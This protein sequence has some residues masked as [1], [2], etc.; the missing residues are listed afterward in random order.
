MV[1]FDCPDGFF[2][3]FAGLSSLALAPFSRCPQPTQLVTLGIDA[4]RHDVVLSPSSCPGLT[5]S[6]IEGDSRS[7]KC[8][9]GAIN[10]AK[11][12]KTRI[13]NDTYS[14]LTVLLMVDNVGFLS[15]IS[16]ADF[17]AMIYGWNLI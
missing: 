8:Y 9:R 12:A 13:Q 1:I 17:F 6:G 11:H 4:L 14:S 16:K 3:S 5:G 10:T 15:N 7:S 2:N